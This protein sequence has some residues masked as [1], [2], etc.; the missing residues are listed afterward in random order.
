MSFPH[1]IKITLIIVTPIQETTTENPLADLTYV[2][3]YLSIV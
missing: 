1:F 3:D 2:T